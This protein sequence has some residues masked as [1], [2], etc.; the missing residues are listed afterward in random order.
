MKFIKVLLI[1]MMLFS[2][3][4]CKKVVE[5]IPPLSCGENQIEED[6]K[7]VIVNQD[8][9][10]ITQ[11][12]NATKELTNYQ[13]DV[14]VE[15]SK[16]TIEYSYE[17]ILKF[18]E[19]ISYFEIDNEQIF[20]EQVSNSVNQYT[21]QGDSY[22]IKS[23]DQVDG[24]G[25]YQEL[26]PSWFTKIDEEF[27]LGGQYLSSVTA[28]IQAD[29]PDGNINN[30]KVKLGSENLEYFMFDM[31]LGEETYNLKFTFS[32]FDQVVLVLPTV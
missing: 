14:L 13:I 5:D 19:N 2:F 26:E 11:A 15:Y 23:V 30:F 31:I 6:G 4:G 7:C 3:T 22:V 9:E 25:F 20:Y 27:L 12:L 1:F 21:K 28:L 16:N 29:F 17:M 24:Y 18:D 8:L 32:L 10:D